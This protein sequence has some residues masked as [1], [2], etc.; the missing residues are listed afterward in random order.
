MPLLKNTLLFT[1]AIQVLVLSQLLVVKNWNLQ[2]Y[3]LSLYNSTFARAT[4]QKQIQPKELCYYN[5]LKHT[6][7]NRIKSYQNR[8]IQKDFFTLSYSQTKQHLKKKIELH[9]KALLGTPYLWGA[10]G[11]N[12]FDCSGFTQKIYNIAG[13][14]IPRVSKDQAKVGKYIDYEN[15]QRGDMVFFAT[16]KKHPH[17]VNHVGIYLEDENFIHASSGSKRV[18]ITSFKKK[19]YYR[20]KFLWGRRVIS[21]TIV[22]KSTQLASV[23][24]IKDKEMRL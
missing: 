2:K 24:S 5:L 8:R 20:N 13:I 9:A 12:K 14:K 10:T 17:R 6:I 15:L 7:Q 21:D 1:I 16:D 22:H 19:K 23:D 11:P 3:F 18:V 4:V